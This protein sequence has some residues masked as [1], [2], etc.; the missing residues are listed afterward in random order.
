MKL[1][2]WLYEQTIYQEAIGALGLERIVLGVDDTRVWRNGRRVP[3]T[4]WHRDPLGPPF[5]TNLRWGHRFLQ[6]S[7]ILPLYRDD[8][9]TS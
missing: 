4:Q 1:L 3:Q 5:Q 7:L 2:D 8:L 6:A 9:Q